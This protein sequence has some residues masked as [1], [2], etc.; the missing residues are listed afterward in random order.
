MAVSPICQVQVAFDLLGDGM[1]AVSTSGAV[2]WA[3]ASSACRAGS[4]AGEYGNSYGA[5]DDKI[6]TPYKP[7][8][9]A[10][11]LQLCHAQPNSARDAEIMKSLLSNDFADSCPD[12]RNHDARIATVRLQT[13][14]PITHACLVRPSRNNLA[15]S[16]AHGH[17]ATA[18]FREFAVASPVQS[19]L[20]SARKASLPYS[21]MALHAT[22]IKPTA[23]PARAAQQQATA[24]MFSDCPDNANLCE[25][26]HVE[27]NAGLTH[28]SAASLQALKPS[29]HIKVS[30]PLQQSQAKKHKPLGSN[31]SDSQLSHSPQ[32]AARSAR[33]DVMQGSSTRSVASTSVLPREYV[34]QATDDCH[35]TSHLSSSDFS[36]AAAPGMIV[37]ATEDN[38][39]FQTCTQEKRPR[40][41]LVQTVLPVAPGSKMLLAN[42][43]KQQCSDRKDAAGS[44]VDHGELVIPKTKTGK[45]SKK[46]EE[47]EAT[48][49]LAYTDDMVEV[50]SL[51]LMQQ[52]Q[53]AVKSSAA[54]CL[55]LLM[56]G[57]T[58]GQHYYSTLRPQSKAHIDGALKTAAK[59]RE[60]GGADKAAEDKRERQPSVTNCP[61]PAAGSASKPG[62]I[63]T[64][65]FEVVAL[66]I[67]PLATHRLPAIFATP[68][69]HSH[70]KH[71]AASPAFAAA[72]LSATGGISLGSSASKPEF[73]KYPDTSTSAEKGDSF[74]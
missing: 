11:E 48:V 72:S 32:R 30:R 15:P 7:C 40:R 73:D 25:A 61:Q 69:L 29:A 14:A 9:L 45:G 50:T 51:A 49:E 16:L 33:V 34:P 41:K 54:C 44:D 39:A 38:M 3:T 35:I 6:T 57:G 1:S 42:D 23:Y 53:Q 52:C 20:C 8:Q 12:P 13:S 36:K 19:P 28:A 60:S 47:E 67:L 64:R 37:T 63:L 4:L 55:A 26:A 59:Q 66:A 56:Q 43:L 27:A 70:G 10:D 18:A 71:S 58:H 31:S 62:Q 24:D 2:H 5:N 65:P 68:P 74:L 17:A 46:E 21:D 22:W